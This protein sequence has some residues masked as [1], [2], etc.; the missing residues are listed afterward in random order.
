MRAAELLA[1]RVSGGILVGKVEKT[2]SAMK[3]YLFIILWY[4]CYK[5]SP[6]PNTVPLKNEAAPREQVR[7]ERVVTYDEMDH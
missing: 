7:E 5:D 2:L 3:V 1:Q 6:C 4:I